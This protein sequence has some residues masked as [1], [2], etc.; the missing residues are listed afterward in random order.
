MHLSSHLFRIVTPALVL[1]GWTLQSARG[2]ALAGGWGVDACLTCHVDSENAA[3][4]LNLLRQSGVRWV[5]ERG[6]FIA[7]P[8][9]AA[10]GGD[11]TVNRLR[12]MKAAGLRVVA[13]VGGSA[14]VER[15]E[16]QLPENLL[17]VYQAAFRQGRDCAE[18][19]D[20]WEMTG[21]PD[22]GYCRDLPDR[23]AAFN[24]ALFLGLHDGAASVGKPTIVLMGALALPAGPWLERAAENGLLDYTDGYNFHYYGNSHELAGHIRGHRQASRALQPL[25]WPT[26]LQRPA[27]PADRPERMRGTV[28]RVPRKL[29]L[30]ITECGVNATAPGDFLNAE[31]RAFQAEFTRAT[32]R[33][34]WAGRDVAV[35]MPFILVHAGD[36]HALVLAETMT[37]LPAW[38][39]YAQLTRE[40][41]WPDRAL[42]SEADRAGRVVLQWMPAA[43]TASHKVSGTY[44]LRGAEPLN[45]EFRLYNFSDRAVTG[46]LE[47]DSDSA[48]LATSYPRPIAPVTIPARGSVAVPVAYV[49]KTETGYF[50]DWTTVRFRVGGRALAQ[51][52]FGLERLPEAADFTMQPVALQTLAGTSRL[53][54]PHVNREGA[55][56]APW[57][58]F[59]GLQ[60]TSLRT[61]TSGS[62][63]GSAMRF[64]APD[65]VND[66]LAPTYALAALQGV[67]K[68]ARFL[69]LKLNRPMARGACVRVDLVDEDGQ[70]FTIWEN[71]GLP[72]GETPWEVWLS[73]ADF[74]PY[75]WSAVKP[76]NRRL[77]PERVRE[78][79]LRLYLHEKSSLDIEVEW[80]ATK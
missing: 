4:G 60:A 11:E 47:P 77:R 67:P 26:P 7:D 55:A 56:A 34:A 14:P 62:P 61:E 76:G 17:A 16:N 49:P 6:V 44:R 54:P 22:V 2:Q 71:F 80:A 1:L 45:G 31:R 42:V 18:I 25:A 35:F 72:Y 15:P 24:K 68:G 20:A 8:A 39:A 10:A 53:Y 32:A 27:R 29:P 59:N 38:D 33:Q 65:A 75:L 41:A 63:P 5:R 28:I 79:G 50:R 69:R 36:P 37:P 43:G 64:S 30:W 48:H 52:A 57:R 51:V 40:V 3:R 70:R 19:V 46:V 66:P 58:L 74:H 13:F 21:E 12:A 78:I 23:L 9:V 73:L